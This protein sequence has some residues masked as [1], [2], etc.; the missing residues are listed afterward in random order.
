MSRYACLV[1]QAVDVSKPLDAYYATMESEL[2]RNP[3]N[4][5]SDNEKTFDGI[6]FA[7]RSLLDIGAG[8]GIVSSYAACMGASRVVAL[9]PEAA[10]SHLGAVRAKFSRVRMRSS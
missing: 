2:G 9:E 3:G 8:A 5:R 1:R 6:E 4:L 7:G 10:G